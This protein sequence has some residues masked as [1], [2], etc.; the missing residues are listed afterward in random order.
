MGEK[1]K[2]TLL[3]SQQ[4]QQRCLSAAILEVDSSKDSLY[5][6]SV[7]LPHSQSAKVKIQP[8]TQASQQLHFRTCCT[9]PSVSDD[10]SKKMHLLAVGAPA[11]SPTSLPGTPE[12]SPNKRHILILVLF[13]HLAKKL[14]GQSCSLD[15]TSE[16]YKQFHYLKCKMNIKDA[17]RSSCP[18]LLRLQQYST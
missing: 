6:T 17:P 15:Y 5:K 3:N 2:R 14:M 4:P 13:C 1:W 7:T 12:G 16:V 9:I 18:A 11:V 8:C 10:C